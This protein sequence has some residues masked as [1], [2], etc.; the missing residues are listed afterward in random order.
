M[1]SDHL[2]DAWPSWPHKWES[3]A[4]GAARLQSDLPDWRDASQLILGLSNGWWL[5]ATEAD[6]SQ[7]SLHRPV[8]AC[9]YPV[10]PALHVVEED[11]SVERLCS[12]APQSDAHGIG[13]GA[14]W[15][16][17]HDVA[18]VEEAER[19]PAALA[20]SATKAALEV[21]CHPGPLLHGDGGGGGQGTE[22]RIS[23]HPGV[24]EHIDLGVICQGEVLAHMRAARRIVLPRQVPRQ[25]RGLNAGRPYPG[26]RLQPVFAGED[27]L[28][29]SRLHGG[30]QAHFDAE[31]RERLPRDAVK[32]GV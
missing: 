8:C 16:E 30:V 31:A 7:G 27:A 3:T 23:V 21:A 22:A 4:G 26:G 15:A 13:H 29:T 2:R 10:A 18:P 9:E 1:E 14:L 19:R 12:R 17:A 20:F 32:V 28:G 11:A 24:T 6:P 25:G 5:L